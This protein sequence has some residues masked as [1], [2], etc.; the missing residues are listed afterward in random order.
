MCPRITDYPE[1]I[2]FETKNIR[3]WGSPFNRKYSALCYQWHVPNNCKQHPDSTAY[4]CC[5]PCKQLICDIDALA[6]RARATTVEGRISRTLPSSNYQL[7]KLVSQKTRMKNVM[8][9]RKSSL[10]KLIP[11]D[12]E[13]SEKQD[14][15]LLHIVSQINRKGSKVIDELIKNGDEVLGEDNL[16]RDA[17]R[18]DVIERLAYEK[19]QCKAGRY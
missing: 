7:S 18:Q 17:W 4:T 19:D 9:D 8:V 13:V 16:L 1:D 6:K 15:E 14:S 11:F 3:Q 12:C 5:K 10:K 2:R